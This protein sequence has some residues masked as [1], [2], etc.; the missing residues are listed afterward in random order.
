MVP[1]RCDL[2]HFLLVR[3]FGTMLLLRAFYFWGA[4]ST[5]PRAQMRINADI[6]VMPAASVHPRYSK[7]PGHPNFRRPPHSLD[8]DLAEV[9]TSCTN[10]QVSLTRPSFLESVRMLPTFHLSLQSLL[11]SFHFPKPPLH[12]LIHRWARRVGVAF[13]RGRAAESSLHSTEG[14]EGNW[15]SFSTFSVLQ[16]HPAQLFPQ[17]FGEIFANERGRKAVQA[18]G[19]AGYWKRDSPRP[20]ES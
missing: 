3:I 19:R 10:S 8:F 4:N 20:P 16:F 14:T 2:I 11:R 17:A 15:R 1:F 18:G 9:K 12:L 5:R 13:P 6:C 7:V